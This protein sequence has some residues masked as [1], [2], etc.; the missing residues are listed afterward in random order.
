MRQALLDRSLFLAVRADCSA[1]TLVVQLLPLRALHCHA[2][3]AYSNCQTYHFVDF[4]V[5]T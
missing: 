4:W 1:P 3:P 2:A 5:A